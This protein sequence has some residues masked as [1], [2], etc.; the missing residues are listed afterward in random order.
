MHHAHLDKFAYQESWFHQLDSRVKCLVTLAFTA[1]IISLNRT[2]PIPLFLYAVGPFAV[3]VWVG[4]PLRFVGKHL[5]WLCPF[6]I[7]LA[8]SF[9]LFDHRPVAVR[10]ARRP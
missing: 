3:L 1:V 9:P 7:M 2:H 10:R 8:V 6:M 5:L 4:V